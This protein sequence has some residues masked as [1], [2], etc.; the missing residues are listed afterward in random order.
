MFQKTH[1]YVYMM[2]KKWNLFMDAHCSL[3]H[4]IHINVPKISRMTWVS[5]QF[6]WK[7]VSMALGRAKVKMIDFRLKIRTDLRKLGP[8]S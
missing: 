1:F 2:G 3:I 6:A 7:K 4:L 5:I 8:E